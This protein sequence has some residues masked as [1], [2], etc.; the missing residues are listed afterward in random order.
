MYMHCP[1]GDGKL[2]SSVVS[3]LRMTTGLCTLEALADESACCIRAV[4]WDL[5]CTGR[6]VH[7]RKGYRATQR[8]TLEYYKAV[9]KGFC[10][11]KIT[12]PEC[13]EPL[14]MISMC[15]R[16]EC[17]QDIQVSPPPKVYRD[18]AA[19]IHRYDDAIDHPTDTLVQLVTRNIR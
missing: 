4:N 18:A 10:R 2:S 11:E 17:G 14:D 1:Q 6:R 5:P 8:S 19:P 16:Q 9:S 7:L 12:I 15:M 3:S 13:V